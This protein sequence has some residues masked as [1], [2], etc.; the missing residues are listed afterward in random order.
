MNFMKKKCSGIYIIHISYI[1]FTDKTTFH[2]VHAVAESALET[3]EKAF[4]AF[5]HF[6]TLD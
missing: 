6:S 5:S 3:G 4:L 2:I 1:N